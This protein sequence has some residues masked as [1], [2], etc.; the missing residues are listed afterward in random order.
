VRDDIG[1]DVHDFYVDFYV[2]DR[3]GRPHEE[4]TARF[5]EDF[6]AHFYRHSASGA[7]RVM[8]LNC[9]KLGDF[10]RR[11]RDDGG[12]LVV[13]ITGVSNVPDV[14]YIASTY[15]AYDPA[16][17]VVKGEP[18]LLCENTTTL[19]DVVLNRRQTDKLLELK[20]GQLR[21]IAGAAPVAAP[22]AQ[23]PTGRAVVVAGEA[24]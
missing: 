16:Q 7:H 17:P 12:K 8:M 15:D 5:D 6:E 9:A 3:N 13:E 20:D 2:V 21:S 10:A 23:P 19:V 22:L 1:V 11:L 18:L 24:P 14:R 4:L